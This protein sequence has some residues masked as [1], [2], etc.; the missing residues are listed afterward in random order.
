M[1]AT[2]EK[3][4]I[5]EE[6]QLAQND[7][8]S[9]EVQVALLTQDINKLTEHFKTAPKDHHSKTGLIKK[10]HQ[11]KSLLRYLKG[12]DIHRYRALIEKFNLRE[13]E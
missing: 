8:G 1:L 13:K 9:V 10:V 11:R 4:K 12:Q 6:H 5:I 2:T 3:K 7:T